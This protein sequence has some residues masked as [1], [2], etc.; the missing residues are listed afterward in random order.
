VQQANVW[1]GLAKVQA[2][3]TAFEFAAADF[4]VAPIQVLFDRPPGEA[5]CAGLSV[6]GEQIIRPG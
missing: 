2:Q 6:D 1:W 3:T 5:T 4:L